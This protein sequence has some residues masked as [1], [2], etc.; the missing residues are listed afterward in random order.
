MAKKLGKYGKKIIGEE[1][2]EAERIFV[3]NKQHK[4]G[5]RLL[6]DRPALPG[7]QP[8]PERIPIRPGIDLSVDKLKEVLHRNPHFV[9]TI[10]LSRR[11]CSALPTT[12][13][14]RPKP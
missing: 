14:L 8:D 5:P 13:S 3:K 1:R 9:A 7:N 4:Y 6:G 12:S 11:P 10:A 2:F